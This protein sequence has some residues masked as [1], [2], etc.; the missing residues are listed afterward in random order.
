[1]PDM[2]IIVVFP[3]EV[4]VIGVGTVDVELNPAPVIQGAEAR[5]REGDSVAD[6]QPVV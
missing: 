5:G 2:L 4:G 6:D 3:T 1:M